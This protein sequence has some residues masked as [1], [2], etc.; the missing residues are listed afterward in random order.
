MTAARC[1]K[2]RADGERN[3]SRQ[4]YARIRYQRC[5]GGD[6]RIWYRANGG[7]LTVNLNGEPISTNG[8]SLKDDGLARTL[9]LNDGVAGTYT[10][11]PIVS[12][13]AGDGGHYNG[14]ALTS[15]GGNVA[16][17]TLTGGTVNV[18]GGPGLGIGGTTSGAGNV[19]ITTNDAVTDLTGTGIGAQAANGVVTVAANANVTA[20][21]DAIFAQATG[22]GNVSVT[23]G[24]AG[25]PVTIATTAGNIHDAVNAF[26]N[27][28]NVSVAAYGTATGELLGT[29]TGNGSVTIAANG[30]VAASGGNAAIFAETANGALAVT[31]NAN[32]NDDLVAI[33]TGTG[34]I[35]VVANGNIVQQDAFA[36]IFASGNGG[37]AP[38]RSPGILGTG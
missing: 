34:N 28:G 1:R 29:T 23:A 13:T 9:T 15:T 22:T 17:T 20:G 3:R 35:A 38:S 24:S 36:S 6:S 8:I 19:A 2:L 37:N 30:T 33:G 10:A 18:S 26:S 32:L 12:T 16:I 21:Q 4:P 5:Q 27:G 11:A 31:T 14:I 25:S 7:D